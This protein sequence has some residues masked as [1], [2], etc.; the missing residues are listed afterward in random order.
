MRGSSR[1]SRT[2]GGRG[3]SASSN[4][5][6]SS[7]SSLRHSS[8]IPLTQ[9]QLNRAAATG[10]AGG[11]GG[12]AAMMAVDSKTPDIKPTPT[13]ASFTTT[14]TATTAQSTTPLLL[15]DTLRHWRQEALN[16]QLYGSAVFWGNKVA[17]MTG[18]YIHT[19]VL[20]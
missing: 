18:G 10:D 17:C 9:A 15:A 19:S 8:K 16:N 14:A 4:T 1:N 3:D 20:H 12:G 6:S 2:R 11:G 13:T 7:V 5:T